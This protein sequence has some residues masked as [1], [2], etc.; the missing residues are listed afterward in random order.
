MTGALEAIEGL[1]TGD[2]E[3]L[4]KEKEVGPHKHED[5]KYVRCSICKRV[6]RILLPRIQEFNI[7]IEQSEKELRK[8]YEIERTYLKSQVNS[9]KLYSRWAKPYLKAAQQLEMQEKGREPALVKSFNT[10]LLE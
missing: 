6:K 3:L 2:V 8:R 7:W 1:S 10:I 9:L 5:E 4:V